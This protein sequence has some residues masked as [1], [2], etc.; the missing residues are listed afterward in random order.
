M[1]IKPKLSELR[2]GVFNENALKIIAKFAF[3]PKKVSKS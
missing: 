2:G 3:F 1:A